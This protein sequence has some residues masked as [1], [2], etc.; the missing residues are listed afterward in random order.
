MDPSCTI[1]STLRCA[2]T[3]EA[4]RSQ[5]AGRPG[6]L[7]LQQLQGSGKSPNK[8]NSF[9]RLSEAAQ[10]QAWVSAGSLR[11]ERRLCVY[12][13]QECVQAPCKRECGAPS[14]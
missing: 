14:F 3:P 8:G 12:T 9:G 11:V 6:L 10:A 13:P 1:A 4:P 7:L 5:A 2:D